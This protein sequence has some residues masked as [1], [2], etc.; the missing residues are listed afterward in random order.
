MPI[1]EETLKFFNINLLT[2]EESPTCDT[3]SSSD[4]CKKAEQSKPAGKHFLCF[5]AFFTKHEVNILWYS[6]NPNANV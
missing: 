3:A 6:R 2:E 4:V 1:C 5:L